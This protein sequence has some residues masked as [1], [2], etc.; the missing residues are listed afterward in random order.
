MF[1]VT[2]EERWLT[3]FERAVLHLGVRIRRR[4]PGEHC[5]RYVLDHPTLDVHLSIGFTDEEIR[6]SSP[7]LARQYGRLAAQDLL[8]VQIERSRI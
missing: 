8:Q 2:H 3:S 4:E 7:W 6:L 5:V 1:E